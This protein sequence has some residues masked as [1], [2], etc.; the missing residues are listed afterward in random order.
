MRSLM[1]GTFN[2]YFSGDQILGKMKW[3]R[4]VERMGC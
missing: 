4:H 2:R 3:E 1:I